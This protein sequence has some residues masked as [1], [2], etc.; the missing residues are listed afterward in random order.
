MPV[1]SRCEKCRDRVYILDIAEG[2]AN[3]DCELLA[4]IDGN[5]PRRE[6][7]DRKEG[8]VRFVFMCRS[9]VHCRRRA[10]YQQKGLGMARSVDAAV[11]LT[12]AFLVARVGSPA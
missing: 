10:R 5:R 7:I 12:R 8:P 4:S 1:A 3:L 11:T 2:A 6:G 9:P